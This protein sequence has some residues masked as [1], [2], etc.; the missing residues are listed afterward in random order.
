MR[1]STRI[2]FV[3]AALVVFVL[4]AAEVQAR[5]V[6]CGPC[7]TAQQRCSVNCFGLADSEIGSCLVGCD[8]AAAICSCDEAVTLRSEDVVAKF[9]EAAKSAKSPWPDP[10]ASA[11]A[12]HSTTPC[13]SGYSSCASWS[14]FIDCGDPYCGFAIGCGECSGGQCEPGGPGTKQNLER[15][16]VC[17]NSQG[18][19]CTEYQRSSITLYCGC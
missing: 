8:N 13:G 19:Q 6:R 9:A 3:L 1:V 16:R 12:C 2:S 10:T 11:A 5:A 18:Q 4:S 14:T 15:Y 7:D 17:F